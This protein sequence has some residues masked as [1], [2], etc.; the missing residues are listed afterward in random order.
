MATEPLTPQNTTIVL[1]D[2][3]VGFSN[4]LRSHNLA[5]HINNAVG[6]AKTAVRYETGLVV[7][8]GVPSKPSGPLYPELLDVI[9]DRPV[10]ERPGEYNAF[11][12]ENFAR[13]VR[14]TGREKI[15]VAGV[16][17]EGCVLQTVLGGQREG[18]D[19]HVVVDASAS[20]TP[21]THAT[22]VERMVQAGVV[23]LTW[24]SLAGEFA[25]DQRRGDMARIQQ[26]LMREHVPE[27]ARGV[28]AFGAAQ[29]QAKS[30]PA[31]V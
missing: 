6:L 1:V 2:F 22:A 3:A 31:A 27:M 21:E 14:D 10:I 4:V 5:T 18:Y 7:T 28:Q 16:S 30:A 24:Y 13:A 15:V 9:G 19:M 17:T 11:L 12:E 29:G 25:V 23:P 20:V 8:N 26:S